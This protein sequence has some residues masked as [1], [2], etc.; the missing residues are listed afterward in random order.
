MSNKILT[1]LWVEASIA[2]FGYFDASYIFSSTIILM[3]AAIISPHELN[4]DSDAVETA[5][6]ILGSMRDSG[7]VPA[8]DYYDQLVQL[9]PTLDKLSN[10]S[11]KPSS[12]EHHNADEGSNQTE[13]DPSSISTR[14]QPPQTEIFSLEGTSTNS[15]T[16]LDDPFIQ[17]FLM[18]TEAQFTAGSF[19]VADGPTVPWGFEWED[20]NVF[21]DAP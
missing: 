17:N 11:S 15:A 13:L 9:K 21:G 4:R 20:L 19:G 12:G 6:S 2:M 3:M 5:W 14:R 7:N 18:Q 8:S 16:I 10:S 1:E